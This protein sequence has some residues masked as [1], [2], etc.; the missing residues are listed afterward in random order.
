MSNYFRRMARVA[1]TPSLQPAREVFRPTP[2]PKEQTALEIFETP[3]PNAGAG[4]EKIPDKSIPSVF[5]PESPV[6]ARIVPQPAAQTGKTQNTIEKPAP[7]VIVTSSPSKSLPPEAT[8]QGRE[9]QMSDDRAIIIDPVS[10]TESM[11]KNGQD[12]L[13]PDKS[14]ANDEDAFR[15]DIK[16]LS[17][18]TLER[19]TDSPCKQS[20]AGESSRGD[21]RQQLE[22]SANVRRGR[23]EPCYEKAKP[24]GVVI[25]S[26]EVRVTPP[27]VPEVVPPKLVVSSASPAPGPI[28]RNFPLFGLSQSY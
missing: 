4:P 18:K 13:R 8:K 27:P 12:F 17:P 7:S 1:E 11:P 3:P 20:A 19:S 10:T 26:L 15:T 21:A 9:N 28:S 14:P 25:H 2:A 5:P 23:T 22:P 6:D 24:A 16:N